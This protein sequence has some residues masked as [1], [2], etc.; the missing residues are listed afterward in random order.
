MPDAF[1]TTSLES[2]EVGAAPVVRHFLLRLQLEPLLARF[3]PPTTRR[4]EAVPTSVTLCAL[5]TNLLLARRL[6]YAFTDW[7]SRRGGS[8][9]GGTSAVRDRLP[10]RT[11]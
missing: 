4:P 8:V 1:D 9:R 3:L 7:A 5:I 11:W 10:G 2:L 6:L